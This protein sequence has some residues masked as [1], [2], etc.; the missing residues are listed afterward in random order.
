MKSPLERRFLPH[1]IRDKDFNVWSTKVE[2]EKI[3]PI[4]IFESGDSKERLEKEIQ[5]LVRAQYEIFFYLIMF[6]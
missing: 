3:F 5:K 2:D 1:T 4:T 6:S